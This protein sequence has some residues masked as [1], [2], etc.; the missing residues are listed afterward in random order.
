MDGSIP[1][2]TLRAF[3]DSMGDGVYGV[4][5]AGDCVFVN[6]SAL[7]ILRY[8]RAQELVGRN[9]HQAIHHTR[10]DGAA[11]P[12]AACPLLHVATS[13]R[14]VRLENELLWRR[15][16]TSFYAE[17]SSYPTR[18]D[19]RIVGSVITFV[20]N[21]VRK[22]A[23]V[24]LA[25]QRAVSEALA[26]PASQTEMLRR[27]M[28]MVGHGFG[29]DVGLFWR[30]DA[31]G[32]R[33]AAEWVVPNTATASDLSR[34]GPGL[35]AR[36]LAT[37]EPVQVV[38]LAGETSDDRL[39]AAAR[40]G[41]RS[42]FAF[43]VAAS[44]AVFG[45]MEF[46]V[47]E[48][49]PADD[50][51]LEALGVL[52][53]MVGLSLQR[54]SM[55]RDLRK[56]E[57]RF[58][59]IANAIPQLAWMTGPDGAI[60]WY[61]DRWYD[62]TGTTADQM[63]GW[64]WTGVHHPD[65]VDRVTRHLRASFE[66]GETWEDT[67]PLR[68]A[69]GRYRWF[70]SRA[71]PIH[72][73][74][75]DDEPPGS[76][77][78]WFGTNTDITAL[79][80]AEQS[81]TEA[82]AE[83]EAANQAKSLFLANMSHE[84]RTPLSAIIGYSEM[85]VEEVEEGSQPDELVRDIRKVETNARHLLG[86]I[87]D[88]LDLSKV[89]SGKMEA[90]AEV[91]DVAG[92]VADVAGT[93]ET[94]VQKRNNRLDI[95]LGDGVGSMYSDITRIRQVILNLISNAAKFTEKGTITLSVTREGGVDGA[96]MRFAV[97]D[98]GLGM[99]AEQVAKLFQ[100][101]QQ[102]DASTTRKF[103]GTGLGLS[104]TKAFCTLLGGDID[105]RSVPGQGSVFTMRV[106]AD[107]PQVSIPAAAGP[108]APDRELVLVIDDDTTQLELM[109]RF[110]ERTGYTARVAPD[111]PTGLSLARKLTPHAILLD[112]TMPG[113][114]GWSVLTA[115]KADPGLSDI[116]VVM[117][118]FAE[119]RA[120]AS[121]LGAADYVMKPVDWNRLALVMDRFRHAEGD[122]L[123]VDDDDDT[124][125]R[126][127][128]GLEKNGWGV[129]EAANGHEAL[130]EVDRALPRLILLDLAMPVMDGF[131]FLRRL[132]ERP[133]CGAVPVVV[134]TALDLTTDDRRRLRGANQVLN[135]GRISLNE[136]T[137]KLRAIRPSALE[138][139]PAT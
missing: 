71:L 98:T 67:F 8:D 99:S 10:P 18:E 90:Y 80:E 113:M 115:L 103:G 19:G 20:E 75:D 28:R 92:M 14:P 138:R 131:E 50:G 129:A 132:R 100:Q 27:V 55:A 66:A 13:G 26:A 6:E 16:G 48:Q 81:Q 111:G 139:P 12:Q 51:M 134:L 4:D 117:V 122:V 119:D 102:G 32:F 78:G 107:L 82:L 64:G 96:W 39:V 77:L 133:G 97:A 70:L 42:G 17:Y 1:A 69:D 88:V 91:F 76:I 43:P 68:A 37:G 112:V 108:A 104:L 24:R 11:Y 87:N 73:G 120:L 45:A 93:V 60:T 124:R 59:L 29:W 53:E 61:N 74:P 84:L 106:P 41:L 63:A 23:V 49:I 105:V 5:L 22:D 52:G 126:L 114:D 46:Y 95:Q 83:A 121:S 85:L 44:G 47:R 125:Q 128:Q 72:A 33:V 94:L 54:R 123:V 7:R 40:Q 101:F 30:K 89:E 9:M 116:P 110:L 35:A 137:E 38:D 118:T 34:D 130:D 56:S 79:R 135:K 58:R 3:V 15:D 86:L 21:N 57:S 65:H 25:V 109:A 36:A 31:G 2:R 127:R 136:L 62:F